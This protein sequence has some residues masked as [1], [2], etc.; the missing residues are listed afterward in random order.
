MPNYQ[1]TT[2]DS[3]EGGALFPNVSRKLTFPPDQP[4][5][6]VQTCSI[7]TIFTISIYIFLFNFMLWV[8]PTRDP[9]EPA[10][11]QQQNATQIDT[12]VT[13]VGQESIRSQIAQRNP[14]GESG[15]IFL[16]NT[17]TCIDDEI[18]G[19]TTCDNS[20]HETFVAT[21][22][23]STDDFVSKHSKNFSG[24]QNH[25]FIYTIVHVFS[26]FLSPSSF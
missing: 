13:N 22:A 21:L 18:S 14:R 16:N 12:N 4:M 25:L 23:N 7:H 26:T 1:T 11:Q 3:D 15:P 8:D 9:T 17:N 19:N 20:T 5:K 24:Y 2:F 10:R 6:R